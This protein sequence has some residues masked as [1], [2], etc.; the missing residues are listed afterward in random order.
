MNRA[1]ELLMVDAEPGEMDLVRNLLAGHSGM[2]YNLN[3]VCQYQNAM[4]FLERKPPFERATRPNLILLNL[5]LP[6]NGGGD[7][8][9]FI[10]SNPDLRAIPVIVVSSS[11]A[12]SGLP[13]DG[14][15]AKALNDRK[16]GRWVN[17]LRQIDQFWTDATLDS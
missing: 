1:F 8:L 2:T 11:E 4:N 6:E 9:R 7:L 14:L 10:K 13:H 12:L 5:Q 15:D 16:A 3:C 17:L